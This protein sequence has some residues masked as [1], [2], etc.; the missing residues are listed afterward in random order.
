MKEG[1]IQLR[2]IVSTYINVTM[3]PPLIQLLYANIKKPQII[4]LSPAWW[5]VPA[6]PAAWRLTWENGLSSGV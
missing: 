1:G 5:Q 4:P 2:Y 6:V 3:K